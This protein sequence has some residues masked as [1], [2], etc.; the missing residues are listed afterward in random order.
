MTMGRL[1]TRLTDRIPTSPQLTSQ[2]IQS[3]LEKVFSLPYA[4][5]AAA[6]ELPLS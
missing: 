1:G 2:S 5:A 6:L 3:C 4:A